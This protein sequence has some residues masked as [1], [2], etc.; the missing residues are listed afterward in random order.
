VSTALSRP[1]DRYGTAGPLRRRLRL[2][3][4]ALVVL[5]AVAGLLYVAIGQARQPVSFEVQAHQ[6][7]DDSTVLITFSVTQ[8][9]GHRA[10]CRLQ[11]LS[12][13]AAQVGLTIVTV[14]PSK[15]TSTSQSATIRTQQ[16]ATTATVDTCTPL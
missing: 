12:S 6:V 10:R 16:R 15:V 3:L 2:A 14:G 4:V 13:G 7:V 9:V 11:A 1:A 8:P 5:A